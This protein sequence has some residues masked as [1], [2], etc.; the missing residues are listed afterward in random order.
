MKLERIRKVFDISQAELSMFLGI[1]RTVISMHE[2]Q[3]RN[4][5]FSDSCCVDFMYDTVFKQTEPSAFD[6]L[7]K[8][9]QHE[10]LQLESNIKRQLASLGHAIQRKEIE[11]QLAKRHYDNLQA[12]FVAI[13]HLK[14]ACGL[15][16]DEAK[17]IKLKWLEKHE[18]QTQYKLKNEG[19]SRI[20]QIELELHQLKSKQEFLERRLSK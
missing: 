4:L 3:R 5:S 20:H 2:L 17:E 1:S 19:L 8:Q 7:H 9:Q 12:R 16:K 13:V 15:T 14:E 6:L 11:L 18:L 10:S